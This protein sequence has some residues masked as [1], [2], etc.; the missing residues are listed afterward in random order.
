MKTK[1]ATMITIATLS[2]SVFAGGPASTASYAVN[3]VREA[4]ANQTVSV[5]AG[6]GGTI[7]FVPSSSGKGGNILSQNSHGATNIA[8]FKPSKKR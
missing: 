1:L 3:R 4:E 2:T 6:N 8:L 5:T 7:T